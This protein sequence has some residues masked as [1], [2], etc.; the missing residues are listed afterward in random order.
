MFE[1]FQPIQVTRF[2]DFT[3]PLSYVRTSSDAS[4]GIKHT[5]SLDP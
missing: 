5:L 4:A 2:K 1:L 3:F